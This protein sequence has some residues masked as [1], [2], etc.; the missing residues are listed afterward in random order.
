MPLTTKNN[1]FPW[2]LIAAWLLAACNL[3]QQASGPSL[4]P[5][6]IDTAAAETLEVHL[7]EAASEGRIIRSST[8]EPIPAQAEVLG[9]TGAPEVQAVE[10]TPQP[11]AD[12]CNQVRFIKD[13]TVPDNTDLEPGEEFTK[14]WR[15][16]NI[17]TCPWTAGYSLVFER[18]DPL[19]GPT[20]IPI[21][22]DKIEPGDTVDISVD[23]VAPP[24]QGS[25]QGFWKLRTA[26]GRRFGI[27]EES[28]AFWVKINVVAGSDLRY[29]FNRQADEAVWGS[30]ELPADYEGVGEN[31]LTFG[32]DPDP[33]R[34]LVTLKNDQRLEGEETSGWIL[35]MRPP[36]GKDRYVMGRF[37]AY[38]VVPG[39]RLKGRA[40]LIKN[41]G[42]PCGLGDVT[43]R[44]LF[45]P[46]TSS[47]QPDQLWEG[48]EICDGSLHD[49]D[50]DL[51]F[52]AGQEVRFVLLVIA[53]SDSEENYPA[54]DAL[55]IVR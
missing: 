17:G 43:F 20:A 40:G 24:D 53:N 9:G 5:G 51:D 41:P 12:P 16:E 54:W 19:S 33:E 49:L 25:Y 42:G 2:L 27:G 32:S 52:L 10:G 21:S 23:L 22:V 47:L 18:G 15:L 8:P 29:D 7:T 48:K 36:V 13:L 50:L 1:L 38:R 31:K 35:E 30:G 6:A 26:R 44:I 39:D 45:Y 34:G 28:E 4:Q 11:E 3:S 14:I 55:A 37:P 46:D